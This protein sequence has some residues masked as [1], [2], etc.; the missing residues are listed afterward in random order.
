MEH[1]TITLVIQIIFYA[2][3][4]FVILLTI[5]PL[6]KFSHW[7]FR[8]GDFPRLQISTICLLVIL[9]LPL[10]A[11]VNYSTI[12]FVFLLA[13]CFAYQISRIIS[14]TRLV[15]MQVEK[16]L[17]PKQDSTI[18]IFI[19]NVLIEN[20]NSDKLLNLI[21]L[22]KPDIILLAEVDQWWDK[23][24]DSLKETYPNFLTYPLD[25]A[26]GMSFYSKLKTNDCQL[27]FI[28]E[29]DIPSIE[30]EIFLPSGVKIKFYGLHPRPPVPQ[31]NY[32]SAERD[33]EI[34]IVGKKI[35][36]SN[37]PTIVAGDLND[38]AWSATN[39]LFQKISG[40]LD[41]RIGRGF[42]NSFHAKFWFLRMPLDHIF[43]STHF[44]LVVI[45]RLRSIGSDHFP[46]FIELSF[47]QDAEIKQDETKSS[48]N[49]KKEADGKIKEGLE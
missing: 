12:V 32:G 33:A 13:F 2:L 49:D 17:D 24:V 41:A 15:S 39:D 35:K 29:E 1:H 44:R 9:V 5:L 48:Q 14:Y 6:F 19:S 4:V 8:I 23:A 40:L 45:K 18:K 16:S 10:F 30:T 21:S 42:Y 43:Q 46:I 26:Y 34:L 28:V 38:V 37:I 11:G 7:I 20:R 31:E 47:E 36:K 3:G 25:N 27:N 22:H